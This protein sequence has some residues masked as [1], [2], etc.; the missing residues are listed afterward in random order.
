MYSGGAI[1][2][3]T[4]RRDGFASM[5]GPGELTTRPVQF[6]GSHTFVNVNGELYAELLD[7][8]GKVLATSEIVT[9][10]HNKQRLIWQGLTDLNQWSGKAVKLRFH[11]AKG[12]LYAFW[13]TDDTKGASHGYV[14]A[15]GSG[16][17]GVRDE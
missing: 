14:A 8:A 4:L 16:F 17:N 10:D 13:I 12:S 15:G 6:K 5:D 3:A 11:L 2:L 7:E 1:G 9:G